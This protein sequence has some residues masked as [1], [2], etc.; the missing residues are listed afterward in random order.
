M[1]TDRDR[2]GDTDAKALDKLKWRLT[3]ILNA[4]VSRFWRTRI[5]RRQQ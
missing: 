4:L 2:P 3:E 1:G 5:D